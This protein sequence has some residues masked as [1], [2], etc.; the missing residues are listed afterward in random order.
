[1]S[2]TTYR[3]RVGGLRGPGLT[4]DDLTDLQEFVDAAEAAQTAAEAAQAAAEAAAATQATVIGYSGQTTVNASGYVLSRQSAYGSVDTGSAAND[5]ERRQARGQA[6]VAALKAAR[7]ESDLVDVDTQIQHW[8]QYGQSLSV[9]SLSN[10]YHV[11]SVPYAIMADGDGTG[12]GDYEGGVNYLAEDGD[13]ATNSFTGFQPMISRLN[14]V[15]M[16]AAA[17]MFAQLLLE[18]NDIDLTEGNHQIL[19]T[20]VGEGSKTIGQL[21]AAPYFTRIGDDFD[22]AVAVAATEEKSYLP[23]LAFW[24]QGENDYNVDTAQATYETALTAMQV[25]IEDEAQASTGN[26]SLALPMLTYQVATHLNYSRTIPKV[27][28]AQL[29]VNR[30]NARVAMATPAYPF[31][32]LSATEVHMSSLGYIY[33]LAYFG[34]AAKRWLIDK[35][36]PFPLSSVSTSRSGAFLR[37]RYDMEP[38]RELVLDDANPLV[39]AQTNYGFAVVDSSDVAQTIEDVKIVGAAKDT[40]EIRL[41]ASVPAG[42]KWRYAWT[43]AVGV[44]GLGNLRDNSP[45]VYEPDGDA[46]PMWKWAAIEEGT[47]A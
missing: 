20:T 8:Q 12:T 2:V 26:A 19:G 15:G 43:A 41:S 35:V 38:G 1:M 36:K 33:M 13:V 39:P 23:S 29:A 3:G 42:A 47:A 24:L 14:E 45:I 46:L 5:L 9:G 32:Y 21:A 34:M 40:V 22:R 6:F 16:G 30:S 44:A 10:P 27:A 11:T 37:I 28:L 25:A 31:R 18:E 7:S 17:R 4:G